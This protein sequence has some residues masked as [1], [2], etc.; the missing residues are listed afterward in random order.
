MITGKSNSLQVLSLWQYWLSSFKSGDTK[1]VKFYPWD[2]CVHLKHIKMECP[3]VWVDLFHYKCDLII[4]TF[5]TSN[6][7]KCLFS[8]NWRKFCWLAIIPFQNILK[9]EFCIPEFETPQP[10]LPYLSS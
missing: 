9:K 8:K 2:E 3:D 7:S 1:L 4:G 6:V 10:V 5:H